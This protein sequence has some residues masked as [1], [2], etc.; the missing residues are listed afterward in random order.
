MRQISRMNAPYCPR[1]VRAFA[2]VYL[3]VSEHR[4]AK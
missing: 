1:L 3:F 2:S 4:E